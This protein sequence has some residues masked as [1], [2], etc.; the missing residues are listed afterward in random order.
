MGHGMELVY[1]QEI[2]LV[3][4]GYQGYPVSKEDSSASRDHAFNMAAQASTSGLCL[5]ESLCQITPQGI[6][7]VRGQAQPAGSRPRQD[8]LR[9]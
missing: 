6:V 5:T 7:Q 2:E 1:I 8:M 4:P 9:I 3:T